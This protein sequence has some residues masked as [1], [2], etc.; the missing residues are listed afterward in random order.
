[1]FFLDGPGDFM[2]EGESEGEIEGALD[3]PIIDLA[4]GDPGRFDSAASSR[5]LS[6]RGG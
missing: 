5:R 4:G 1:V 6:G 2:F 3:L